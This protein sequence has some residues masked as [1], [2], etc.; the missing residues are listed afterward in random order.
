[1]LQVNTNWNCPR[2][3]GVYITRVPL[4]SVLVCPIKF[5]SIHVDSL[6]A[7]SDDSSPTWDTMTVDKAAILY[8]IDINL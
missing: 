6:I 5:L 8:L 3:G 7:V 2:H 1:M 4:F